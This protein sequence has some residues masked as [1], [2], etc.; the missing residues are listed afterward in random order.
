MSARAFGKGGSDVDGGCGFCTPS[1][2]VRNGDDHLV[3]IHG[4]HLRQVQ[5]KGTPLSMRASNTHESRGLNDRNGYFGENLSND[6]HTG[7]ASNFGFRLHV[8]TV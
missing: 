8:D 5:Q 7:D 2:L 4:F 1:F 6:V 3:G